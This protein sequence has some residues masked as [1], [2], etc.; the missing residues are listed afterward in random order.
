VLF[1]SRYGEHWARHWLDVAHYADTHGNDHDYYRPNAWPYRDYVIRAFNQDKPY[2]QFITAQIA[3]DELADD[4]LAVATG[5]LLSGPDMPDINSQE[6]RRHNLLNEMTSTVGSVFLALQ[7]GCAQC[8]DHKYDPVSQKEYF[9]FRAFFEPL[10]L[11]RDRVV[12]EP[13]PL[14]VGQAHH[15][16]HR[17]DHILGTALHPS[18]RIK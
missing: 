10:E 8:H 16:I 6:E 14:I 12:G 3:G 5:F 7:I 15:V 13:D 18:S 11:R 9:A 4:T 17:A 2:D 1:R